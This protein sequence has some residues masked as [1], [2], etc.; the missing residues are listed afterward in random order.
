[1]NVTDLNGF[2]L[3]VTYLDEAIRQS[4][5]FSSYGQVGG[6][7]S[8]FNEKQKAYWSDLHEKLLTLKSKHNNEKF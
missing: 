4:S 1:M 8:K 3:E 6:D 7:C 5:E 2:E